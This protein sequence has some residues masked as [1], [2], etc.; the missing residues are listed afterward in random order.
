M[1]LEELLK[2]LS[3]VQGDQELS[4][5]VVELIE[6]EKQRGI[7]AKSKANKEAINLRKFKK[8]MEALGYDGAGDL[9]EFTAT[10]INN[11]SQRNKSS[12]DDDKLTLKALRDE[13]KREKELRIST[14]NKVREKTISAK[15]TQALN[16]KVYGADLL[17]KSLISDGKVTLTDEEVFFKENE[18]LIPFNDGINKLLET[19]KDIVKSTQR[20]GTG[21]TGNDTR[22]TDP[23][24]AKIVA[25]GD[26]EAIIANMDK[27][28]K[29]YGIDY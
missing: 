25:S 19:R 5:H 18:E 21:S 24:I 29:S 6:A 12:N 22:T 2:M 7:D 4:K 14:E 8:S 16:D 1:E 15:L 20:T 3:K 11:S 10:M 26:R 27:I 28:K 17:V 23:D 13:I 9:D